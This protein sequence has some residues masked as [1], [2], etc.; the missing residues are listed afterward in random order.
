MPPPLTNI[1]S[2]PTRSYDYTPCTPGTGPGGFRQDAATWLGGGV[3]DYLQLLTGKIMPWAVKQYHVS[4][5][6]ELVGACAASA[7]RL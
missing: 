7:G 3:D 5:V 4:S 1:P 2:G 6:P